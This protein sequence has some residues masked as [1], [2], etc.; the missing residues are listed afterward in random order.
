MRALSVDIKANTCQSLPIFICSSDFSPKDTYTYD[1]T[2][3]LANK[4]ASLSMN[5]SKRTERSLHSMI[6]QVTLPPE[7]ENKI[8]DANFRLSI[9]SIVEAKSSRPSMDSLAHATDLNLHLYGNSPRIGLGRPPKTS[10][11]SICSTDNTHGVRSSTPSVDHTSSTCQALH[12]VTTY[13]YWGL[14]FD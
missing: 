8:N 13:V 9:E 12:F 7:E 5:E 6:R 2:V 3:D 11:G 10:F 4:V 14:S 1:C